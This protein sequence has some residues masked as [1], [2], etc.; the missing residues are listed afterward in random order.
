[1][2]L[3]GLSFNGVP[4]IKDRKCTANK[5][6]FLNEKYLEFIIHVDD[7][8][9]VRP[10]QEPVDQNVMTSKVF[11]TLNLVSSNCRRQG[12]LADILYSL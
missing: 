4:I 1:M 2:G 6:F 12:Q 7:N 10:F 3:T 5:V 8:F 11:V 9:V